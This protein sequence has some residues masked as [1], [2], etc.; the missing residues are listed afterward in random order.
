MKD[1]CEICYGVGEV[2][3]INRQTIGC[4]ACLEHDI[5]E[6]ARR[7]ISF[8]DAARNARGIGG[9]LKDAHEWMETTLRQ[10]AKITP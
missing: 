4:P 8:L 9:S 2:D 7:C 1:D 5:A 3:T 6:R 10:L